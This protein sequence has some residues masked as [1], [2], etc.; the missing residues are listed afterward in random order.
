MKALNYILISLV[1]TFMTFINS[2]AHALSIDQF[3]AICSSSTQTCVEH[4]LLQAYVGGALD[5]VASLTEQTSYLKP[6][7]CRE[8]QDI[9]DV[10]SIISYMLTEPYVNGDHNARVLVIR[11]IEVKGAC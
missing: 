6:F 3:K 11:Y 5:M 10:P 9:F 1:V 4:P 7:Y 8:P 2:K